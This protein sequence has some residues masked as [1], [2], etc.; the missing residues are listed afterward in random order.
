MI[1]QALSLPRTP[2][3]VKPLWFIALNA[4]SEM[5]MMEM[6]FVKVDSNISSVK[7]QKGLTRLK[8]FCEIPSFLKSMYYHSPYTKRNKN[9]SLI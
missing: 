1:T 7:Q 5:I 3:D 4:Y 9:L 2:I 6:E 8:P